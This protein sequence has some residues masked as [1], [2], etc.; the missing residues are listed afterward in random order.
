[1]IAQNLQKVGAGGVY[2]TVSIDH[3]ISAF[4]LFGHWHLAGDDPVKLVSRHAGPL[5]GP[6]TLNLGINDAEDGQIT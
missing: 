3:T 6:I 4:N 2:T 1:M 5:H